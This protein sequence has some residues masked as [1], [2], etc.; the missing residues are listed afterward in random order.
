[1]DGCSAP[2]YAMPLS[3]LAQ[4]YARLAQGERDPVYGAAMG[5]LLQ[6]MTAH[7]HLVSGQGR[8]DLAYMRA[9]GGD[10]VSKVGADAVQTIGIRSAGLGIAIKIADGASRALPVATFSVLEQLGLLDE[11]RRR[12]LDAYRQTPILNARGLAV[13]DVRAVFKLEAV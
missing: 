3:R 6:A 9:G 7:P 12:Q 1:M 11:G 2:N 4:L 10:W 8:S 13:G 5:D